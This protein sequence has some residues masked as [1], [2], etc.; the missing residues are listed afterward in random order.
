MNVA[1][2]QRQVSASSALFFDFDGVLVDSV[3]VKTDAFATL[4]T[5]FGTDVVQRVVDHHRRHGGMNRFEKIR[6]YYLEFLGRSLEEDEIT[7]LC[8][9]FS[10]LV[11]EKVI[12]APEIAGVREFLNEY[13]VV[14]PCFV[15]SAT[16]QDELLEIINRRGWSAN[17]KNIRGAPA[18]KKDNLSSLLGEEGLHGVKC[19]YFGDSSADYLAARD[20]GVPF[21]GILPSP[22]APLLRDYPDLFWVKD[23]FRLLPPNKVS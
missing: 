13:A 6:R 5:P 19:L 12:A 7:D 23:F 22:T 11:V 16:P 10:R 17:F 2:L 8:A 20:C 18:S 1:N 4:F 9:Q 21:I 15:V 14:K 3:E